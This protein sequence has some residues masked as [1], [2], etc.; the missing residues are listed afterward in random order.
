MKH[1]LVSLDADGGPELEW[2]DVTVT[3]WEPQERKY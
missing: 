3:K 1:T 2:R